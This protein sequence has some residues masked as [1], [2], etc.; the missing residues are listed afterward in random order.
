MVKE[1]DTRVAWTSEDALPRF[2]LRCQECGH[3]FDP[4]TGLILDMGNAAKIP[5]PVL[6]QY[7]VKL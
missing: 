7:K 4:E 5:Q 6:P 3:L 2:L 1:L